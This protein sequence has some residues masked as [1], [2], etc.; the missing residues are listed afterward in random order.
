MN[1]ISWKVDATSLVV[2]ITHAFLMASCSSDVIVAN[3]LD[4]MSDST[5]TPSSTAVPLCSPPADPFNNLIDNGDFSSDTH[6]WSPFVDNS[7]IT[8][9]ETASAEFSVENGIL[10]AQTT[11]PDTGDTF[12]VGIEYVD[13]NNRCL[14]IGEDRE[15]QVEFDCWADSIVPAWV[16]VGEFGRDNNEDGNLW[17]SYFSQPVN[18]N[19]SPQRFKFRFFMTTT[20]DEFARLAFDFGQES[21]TYHL[22]NVVLKVLN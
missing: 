15:Y 21:E 12:Y 9:S 7:H 3:Q 17:T 20:T 4:G 5:S 19:T 2:V 22:D 11:I 13:S 16:V 8:H 1:A 6:N 10:L 14:R 18:L